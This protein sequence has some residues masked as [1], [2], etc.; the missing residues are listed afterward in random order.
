MLCLLHRL[1]S[2]SFVFYGENCAHFSVAKFSHDG[3]NSLFSNPY[4][5]G[6]PEL[7]DERFAL[8]PA[9]LSPFMGRRGPFSQ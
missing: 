3:S 7:E 4:S 2:G 6:H 1:F 9:S 5:R 8:S